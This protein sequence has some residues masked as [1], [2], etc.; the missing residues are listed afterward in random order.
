MV[1]AI[2]Y[3]SIH[4]VSQDHR[5]NFNWIPCYGIEQDLLSH[6]YEGLKA[7]SQTLT[8]LSLAIDPSPSGQWVRMVNR[9]NWWTFCVILVP[10]MGK[11]RAPRMSWRSMKYALHCL[12]IIKVGMGAEHS[13]SETRRIPHLLHTPSSVLSSPFSNP[14]FISSLIQWKSKFTTTLSSSC[15]HLAAAKPVASSCSFRQ[16]KMNFYFMSSRWDAT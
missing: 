9:C 1:V 6:R 8:F 3:W 15:Y 7:R 14:I 12:P 16:S 4:Y 2:S 13:E 5:L 10:A 11:P